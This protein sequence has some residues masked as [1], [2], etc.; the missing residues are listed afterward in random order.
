MDDGKDD[1]DD[2]TEELSVQA[3]RV[4]NKPNQQTSLF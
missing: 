1:M 3:I 2:R 4:K